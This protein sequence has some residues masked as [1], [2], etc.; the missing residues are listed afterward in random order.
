MKLTVIG[1]AVGLVL[2]VTAA[3]GGFGAMAIVALMGALGALVGRFLDG[4]L[5][6]SA[7]GAGTRDRGPR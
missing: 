4:Q 6:L 7:F 3:W 1:L 5:D 2:G